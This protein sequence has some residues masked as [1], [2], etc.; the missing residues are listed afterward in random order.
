LTLDKYASIPL[1][2]T[3]GYSGITS[4]NGEF[5][6]KGIEVDLSIK[7]LRKKDFTWDLN[8]NATYN[9]NI[10]EKLPSNGLERNRQSAYQVYD[11]KTKEL[12]WVGG[13][14]EGQTPGESG[15]SRLKGF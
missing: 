11:P 4:N 15:H 7:A 6:T 9:K 14:Q 5:R 8:I 10:V 3:S 2:I 12:I 13:Y 1:P